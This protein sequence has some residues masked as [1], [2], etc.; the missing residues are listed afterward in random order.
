VGLVATVAVATAATVA[1]TVGDTLMS[2][3]TPRVGA[4]SQTWEPI[5][6]PPE[7]RPRLR[8]AVV[9]DVGHAGGVIETAAAVEAQ[10]RIDRYDVLMLLGD[11]VASG[12]PKQVTATVFDP[13]GGTLDAGTDLLAVLGNHD[14]QAG[15]GDAVMKALGSPGRW[16]SV[17]RGDVLMIA[18]DSTRV[19]D[20]AQI[21]WLER[22]LGV[23]DATWKLVAL[24]HPP[25]S[26][27]RHGSDETVRATFVPVFERYGVQIVLSGHD[28][29]YQRSDAVNGVT[30]VVTGAG[31][32]PRR[33]GIADFTAVAYSTLHYVD[34]NI[35]DNHILL[36]AIDSHGQQFDEALIPSRPG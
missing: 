2:T 20:P 25:Y 31:S 12:D 34:L 29:D 14:D 9:G 10:S 8:V 7:A 32:A 4:P 16:Y 24:H 1:L 23:T 35:Y 19:S 18:L 17:R 3:R 21:A 30:Y 15:K 28:H 5:Q 33:T 26:S 27:G 22:T 13:F 11:N 36:R 6:M